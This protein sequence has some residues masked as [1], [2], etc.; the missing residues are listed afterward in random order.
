M[1]LL[2]ISEAAEE[3]GLNPSRVRALVAAGVLRGTKIGERWVIES[4]EVTR[5]RRDR[6]A[7]GRPFEPGNAWAVLLLASGESAA[8]VD[9]RVR[10]RLERAL[11]GGG[12][13]TLRSRLGRRAKVHRFHAHPGELHRLR[14]RPDLVKTGISASGAY[15]LGLAAAEEVDAYL[16]KSVLKRVQREH[17]LEL[18]ALGDANVVLRVAPTDAWHLGREDHPDV[19]PP[20]A[21]AVDLAEDADSR[22]SRVGAEMIEKIDRERRSH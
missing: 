5:R 21:V 11:A 13:R 12:L 16:T 10:W 22:S 4:A 15:K 20:A 19:A 18:A 1:P 8:W 7:P 2:S 17:A 14:S 6:G 9:P 3:L